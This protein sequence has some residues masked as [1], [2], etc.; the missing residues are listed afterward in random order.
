MAGPPKAVAPS[1]KKQRKR[2]VKEGVFSKDGIVDSWSWPVPMGNLLTMSRVVDNLRPSLSHWQYPLAGMNNQA[3]AHAYP[4]R[5]S[6]AYI[7]IGQAAAIDQI[8]LGLFVGL[9]QTDA[10]LYH[11]AFLDFAKVS[12]DFSDPMNLL[13][14]ASLC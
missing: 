10:E 6:S 5:R 9:S 2:L 11:H 13:F 4:D 3:F 7:W 12:P 1:V 8:D 14:H